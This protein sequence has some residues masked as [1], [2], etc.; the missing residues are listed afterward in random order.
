MERYSRVLRDVDLPA[1]FSFNI[2]LAATTPAENTNDPTPTSISDVPQFSTFANLRGNI[3]KSTARIAMDVMTIIDPL[4]VVKNCF[5]G[6]GFGSTSFVCFEG[7]NLAFFG[8]VCLGMT[9]TSAASARR[10]V[11]RRIGDFA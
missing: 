2:G 1:S 9:Y 10:E 11:F 4:Y 8:G 5:L 3:L 7:G 6:S